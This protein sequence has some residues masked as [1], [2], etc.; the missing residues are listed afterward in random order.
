[1]AGVAAVLSDVAGTLV[2]DAADASLAA[3]VEAQGMSCVVTQ[4]V[5][6]SVRVA[7]ELALAT[8]AAVR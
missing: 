7:E 3:A 5:M 1:V 6:E 2:V 8:L 4:T